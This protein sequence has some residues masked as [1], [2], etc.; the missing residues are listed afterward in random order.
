MSDWIESL[1]TDFKSQATQKL[2]DLTYEIAENYL[3][4]GDYCDEQN[5]SKV[6]SRVLQALNTPTANLSRQERLALVDDVKT[7][8]NLD[9]YVPQDVNGTVYYYIRSLSQF[10][11]GGSGVT[12]FLELS[13]T[14]ASYSG[15]NAQL[16]LV[17]GS[18]VQAIDI[19]N[20]SLVTPVLAGNYAGVDLW[21]V[22]EG[23]GITPY[24]LPE[25]SKTDQE[26]IVEYGCKVECSIYY[27]YPSPGAGEKL[28]TSVSGDF[29]F[30]VGPDANSPSYTHIILNGA[31]IEVDRS[32][33][34]I[35][36]SPRTGVSVNGNDLEF[37]SGNDTTSDT[38]SVSFRSLAYFGTAGTNTPVE[39][40]ILALATK[41]FG[42]DGDLEYDNV[43]AAEGEYVILAIDDEY[44]LYD[45]ITE[46]SVDNITAAFT[47]FG[48]VSVT[49]TAGTARN[50][51]V[52][53]SVFDGAFDGQTI[54]FSRLG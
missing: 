22:F 23:D 39:A 5:I 10:S 27:R 31:V 52:L 14:F 30:D 8:T 3:T 41:K 1:I 24:V 45:L 13:D 43:N 26:I 28:P 18:S 15:K 9:R 2:G 32:W 4:G 7:L 50:F 40:D 17:Q 54:K 19:E 34:V 12:S 48:V 44:D 33:S 21:G 11:S 49:N 46:D 16:L 36:T 29:G 38:V 37:S 53:V 25:G 51:K 47:N 6:I 35:L 20:L 42:G